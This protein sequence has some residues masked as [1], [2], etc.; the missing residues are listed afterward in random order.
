M[1]RNLDPTLQAGLE[2]GVIVPAILAM[3]TFKSGTRYIW[4]GIGNLI[5]DAQTYFGVGSLGGFGGVTEGVE[6]RADGTTV[7]LSGIDPTLYGES[8]TDIQLGAPA[9]LWFALFSEGVLLGAPY[10]FFSGLV[11]KP[12][13]STGPE[14]LTISLAL[15][16]RMT[17]L[18][19]PSQRRYTAADQHVYYPDDTAFVWVERMNDLALIWGT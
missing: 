13:V 5:F 17:N 12:A 15:E 6:V 19:R 9:R 16:N 7:S 10:L 18:Q 11:D 14:A 3:L 8:M 1:S 4:T 2:S